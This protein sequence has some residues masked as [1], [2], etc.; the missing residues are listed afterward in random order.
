V[1]LTRAKS[2]EGVLIMRLPPR[3][4]LSVG[5]PEHLRKE[6]QRLRSLHA[7]TVP[8]LR[9]QLESVLGQIPT[10]VAALFDSPDVDAGEPDWPELEPILKTYLRRDLAEHMSL[11]RAADGSESVSPV[12]R[13]TKKTTVWGANG[14]G[15]S[16]LRINKHVEPAAKNAPVG[17]SALPPAAVTSSELAAQSAEK[18]AETGKQRG[19]GDVA[20]AERMKQISEAREAQA[21]SE[22]AT[23][24]K[25]F[26]ESQARKMERQ[27]S[28]AAAPSESKLWR[29]LTSEELQ[30]KASSPFC[31]QS[32]QKELAAGSTTTPSAS[33][34]NQ[35]VTASTVATASAVMPSSRGTALIQEASGTEEA[36]EEAAAATDNDDTD[37]ECDSPPC[38]RS[39]KEDASSATTSASSSSLP[40][41]A[42]SLTASSSSD[43]MS[44]AALL[45]MT[46]APTHEVSMQHLTQDPDTCITSVLAPN[47]LDAHLGSGTWLCG[48]QNAGNTCYANSL[49]L[50][51][52]AVP[53][54]RRWTQ[55][56]AARHVEPRAYCVLCS[57]ADDIQNLAS[58][59]IRRCVLP[60]IVRD[61]G[62]WCPAFNN[63]RQQ[64]V[65]E[66]WKCLKEACDRAEVEEYT[67]L[68]LDEVPDGSAVLYT[69]PY[70][71]LCCL[72]GYDKT[73]CKHCNSSI[74]THWVLDML[75][76]DIVPGRGVDL[77][78]CLENYVRT[79]ELQ[80]DDR[81]ECCRRTGN[82]TK[83][84]CIRQWP[85]VLCVQLKRWIPGPLPGTYIKEDR[86]VTKNDI[87]RNLGN[88]P[89]NSYSLCSAVVHH[90]DAGGGHYTTVFQDLATGV[91]RE[92]NDAYVSLCDASNVE[93][94][95]SKAFLLFYTRQE[96]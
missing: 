75:Q 18:R 11:K 8:R 5:P 31:L 67:S 13:L 16:P 56:H 71:K 41:C 66:F 48:Q 24:W 79:T 74:V 68:T 19:I 7:T 17:P 82:R 84:T 3:E 53:L 26:T 92:G 20:A 15:Q 45:E 58:S 49:L 9:G 50:A 62:L 4:A 69:T 73:A 54:L 63:S 57:C 59:E 72:Q 1:M 38:K 35:E 96:V 25:P 29:T 10:D 61:R 21:A 40:A 55:L 78:S 12:R 60:R 52:A 47:L 32:V 14:C 51:V 86:P 90:G 77:A 88:D 27:A 42:P 89:R 37:V 30:A 33:V 65:C 6:M 43:G 85:P 39:R 64:D 80:T 34:T 2:L 81:C 36:G 22:A 93:R 91:W 83:Q 44:S 23:R 70:W 87:L 46:P 76:L 28:A 95:L 94:L